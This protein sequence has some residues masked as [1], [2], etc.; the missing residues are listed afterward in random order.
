MAKINK[1]GNKQHIYL[2]IFFAVAAFFAFGYFVSKQVLTLSNSGYFSGSKVEGANTNGFNENGYNYSAR[3]FVG[4]ADGIDKALDGK[5]WG[6]PTYAKDRLVM[7]WNAEWDRGNLE[8]WSKP[9]YSAWEDNE[10]NGKVP[11]G[12]G[13][14][15]HYKIDW[16]KGCADTGVVSKPGGYCGWGQFEV[17]MDHGMDFNAGPSHIWFAHAKPTGYGAYKF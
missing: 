3:V 14:V 17:V 4:L 11:G 2:A 12:S 15:W 7:K 9:P 6:D 13:Q 8:G 1:Q 16:D 5:V 10:W